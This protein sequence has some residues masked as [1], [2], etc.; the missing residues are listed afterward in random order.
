MTHDAR[1][2]LTGVFTMHDPCAGC[3]EP[4][5]PKFVVGYTMFNRRL[6][7][8]IWHEDCYDGERREG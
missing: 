6:D 2:N 4:V 8:R 7:Y 5:G 3:G 1:S